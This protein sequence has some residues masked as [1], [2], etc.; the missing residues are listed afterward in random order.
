MRFVHCS[1]I[2]L[3]DL[4]GTWPHELM[5]KRVTGALNL[6]LKRR[7]RH[8]DGRFEAILSALEGLEVDRLVITG[9]VTNLSLASEF[10]KVAR[11]LSSCPVPVTVIPGN[12]D[13]YVGSAYRAGLFATHLGAHMPPGD[14]DDAAFPFVERAHDGIAL[15]GVDTAVPTPPLIATGEVGA[16]QLARLKTTLRDCRAEGR[17]R[18]VLM[19]H[20]P[21]EGASK[22]KHDLLD[23]AAFAEV[24]RD[25]GAEVILHGHE[26]REMVTSLPG[27]DGPVP[28]YGVPSG[29]SVDLRPGRE[30]GFALFELKP[31]RGSRVRYVPD[32]GGFAPADEGI[33]WDMERPV[34]AR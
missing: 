24:I 6:L 8:D 30:G 22:P 17:V 34:P 10:K 33:T 23:R 31:G 12:H 20:P 1:D 21:A 7:K 19:H 14:G 16:A 3:L 26:H 27:P 11:V 18:V 2:H 29:T 4:A 25:E 15:I 9:D 28:I 32:N 5:N 13:A